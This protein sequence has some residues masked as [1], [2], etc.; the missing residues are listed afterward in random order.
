VVDV[1]RLYQGQEMRNSFVV[2][3]EGKVPSV[4]IELLSPGREEED[5]GIYVDEQI[6]D[7]ISEDWRPYTIEDDESGILP[8][9]KWDVYDS[10]TQRTGTRTIAVEVAG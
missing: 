3:D 9:H 2:W 1:P 8:P 10:Q 7:A 6:A 4:I 5:L